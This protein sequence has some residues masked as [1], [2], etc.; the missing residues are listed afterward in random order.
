MRV[1]RRGRIILE[2]KNHD[3]YLARMGSRIRSRSPVHLVDCEHVVVR[4]QYA[5]VRIQHPKALDVECIYLP[6]RT[7]HGAAVGGNAGLIRRRTN[8]MKDVRTIRTDAFEWVPANI[9]AATVPL[10]VTDPPYGSIVSEVWDKAWSLTEQWRMTQII[11]NVLVPG[12][13]AYVWG[14]IGKPGNRLFFDWLSQLEAKTNLTV[15]D[16]ITWSKRRAYGTAHRYLFTREECAMLTKG[17]PATF[18]VPLLEEKRGYAGYNPNY[19]A[20]S[21]FKRRTN[22]WTDVTELFKGKIHPCEKPSRLAE[23]MIETSSN[24]GDLVLD[25]FAGSGSTG[26]AAAKLG[27][28]CILLEKTDCPMRSTQAPSVATKESE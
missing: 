4:G 6:R 14:G 27:R 1:P 7:R 17:K 9:P 5:N 10:V 15:W 23:I 2:A 16:V 18:N 8:E 19:P 20:K 22:V 12:G 21:E 11:E 28:T 13:T 26:V 24:P 3:A 25:M